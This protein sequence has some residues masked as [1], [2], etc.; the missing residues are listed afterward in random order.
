M[1]RSIVHDLK[2]NFGQ[3][4][5][6]AHTEFS[7]AVSLVGP[8]TGNH[9]RIYKVSVD[10][11]VGQGAAAEIEMQDGTGAVLHTF[12]ISTE[13]HSEID[14]GSRFI[15]FDT[16]VRFTRGTAQNDAVFVSVFYQERAN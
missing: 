2:N 13:G 1:S 5:T 8:A 3:G 9:L 15:K 14:L 6:V 11:P 16:A 10:G 12:P 4:L 7:G